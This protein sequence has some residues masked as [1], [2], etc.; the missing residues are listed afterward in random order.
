MAVA[1]DRAVLT[2]QPTALGTQSF[3]VIALTSAERS[4]VQE[5]LA[6]FDSG[7]HH[8]E[9]RK[10]VLE[11]LDNPLGPEDVA[12]LRSL[13]RHKP[14]VGNGVPPEA[15]AQA[16][17]PPPKPPGRR[18][19]PPSSAQELALL[20]QLSAELELEQERWATIGPSLSPAQRRQAVRELRGRRTGRRW[21]RPAER[22]ALLL[23]V[24][25]CTVK[26]DRMAIDAEQAASRNGS[27]GSSRR[28]HAALAR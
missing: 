18:P 21:E 6:G 8:H 9:T 25:T 3:V 28:R 20:R 23:G 5:A 19:P 26:R 12:E 27:Y 14:I 10:A 24:S 13:A 22:V 7:Y 15:E 4:L 2:K 17:L 16:P 11:L 1:L